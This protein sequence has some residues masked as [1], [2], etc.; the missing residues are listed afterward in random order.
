LEAEID[1]NTLT[2]IKI[3]INKKD[4]E[5]NEMDALCETNAINNKNGEAIL[6]CGVKAEMNKNEDEVEIVVDSEGKSIDV[7]FVSL[8]SNIALPKNSQT[9][10]DG[11]RTNKALMVKINYWMVIFLLFIFN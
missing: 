8:T 9:P 5:K 6:T 11:G 3:V 1:K 10:Q 4:N 2:Q 7:T